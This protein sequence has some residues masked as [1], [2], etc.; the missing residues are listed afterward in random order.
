MALSV[1]AVLLLAEIILHFQGYG[2]IEIYE[3]DKK[4]FWK[5]R[6][7]QKCFT[8]VGHK[9]VRINSLGTRG[10]EFLAAKPPKTFRILSL[11]DSRTFGWGLSEEDTYSS[12]VAKQAQ[13]ILGDSTKVEIINAGVNAWSYAQMYVYFRDIGLAYNPDLVIIADGNLW[14]QF[15]ENSD[16]D[17]VKKFMRRIWLKNLLRKSALYHFVIEVQLA[18]FYATHREKFIPID[19][20]KDQL[21]QE[22]QQKDPDAFFRDAIHSLCELAVSKKINPIMVYIPT[23]S[24]LEGRMTD[25]LPSK[26]QAAAK[27]GVPLIDFSDDLKKHGKSWMLEGDE[28]HLNVE[29]NRALAS[30]I[31][32][33]MRPILS[34]WSL[35]AAN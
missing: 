19:P 10:P 1:C 12:L 15:S 23:L 7:N 27:Y 21:F 2:Q 5:L 32:E 29:G 16:P 35:N 4:L 24:Q 31:V 28:A 14:T 34:S 20:K 6:S 22:Q 13:Q 18:N 25:V 8:K 9:S 11:G 30:R 3:P 26:K 33:A 17:F